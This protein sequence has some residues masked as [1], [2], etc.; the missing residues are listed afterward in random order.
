[1]NSDF[2]FTAFFG[3]FAG[4]PTLHPTAADRPMACSLY[5]PTLSSTH[6]HAELE[7]LNGG[8]AAPVQL[9]A[10]FVQVAFD[11]VSSN[12][13]ELC[14][15]FVEQRPSDHNHFFSRR[16]PPPHWQPSAHTHTHTHTH[17]HGRHNKH[18]FFFVPPVTKKN[19]LTSRCWW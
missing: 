12:V 9:D 8:G 13:V 11:A 6:S 3:G 1:M 19:Q 5:G 7:R 16:V 2:F 14:Q 18:T 10:N 15:P 4:V 17:K